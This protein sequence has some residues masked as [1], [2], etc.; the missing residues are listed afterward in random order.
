[1]KQLYFFFF[2]FSGFLASQ[3]VRGQSPDPN[4]TAVIVSGVDHSSFFA[5]PENKMVI[6]R[7]KS[8]NET[9]TDH[10]VIE[11]SLD[12]IHFDPLHELVSRGDID[13]RDSSY[14]DEDSYPSAS[15]N[16]YRLKTVDKGGNAFYSAVVM[17]DMSGKEMPVLKPTV[18]HAGSTLRVDGY[19]QQ[20][21]TINFFNGSGRMT[22]TFIVNSSSF[23]V[24]T[25]GWGTGVFFYRISDETHPLIDAGKILVL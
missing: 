12:S 25:T 2:L 13:Q 4:G 17:V 20:P 21:L 19:Y 11:H 24:N 8:G 14:Q 18:L 5:Y 1:M 22:G 9:N 6:M 23:N 10:F 15:A 16:Y 3:G 7:W